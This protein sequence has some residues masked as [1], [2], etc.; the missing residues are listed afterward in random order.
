MVD[1]TYRSFFIAHSFVD[2]LQPSQS[3]SN[4]TKSDNVGSQAV[5]CQ[6]SVEDLKK[7]KSDISRLIPKCLDAMREVLQRFPQHYK[8][9]YRMGHYYCHSPV[10]KVWNEKIIF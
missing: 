10:N 3:H 8:A 2:N 1:L 6:L 9:L 4:S 7:S 5:A